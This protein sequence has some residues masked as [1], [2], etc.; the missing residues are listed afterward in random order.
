MKDSVTSHLIL[1]NN[2]AAHTDQTQFLDLEF[3]RA[4]TLKNGEL[5]IQGTR[6][7]FGESK[8]FPTLPVVGAF[9]ISLAEQM[10]T[11]M[12]ETSPAEEFRAVLDHFRA[13]S[14]PPSS[15]DDQ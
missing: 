6:H 14:H 15:R 11:K 3:V 4:N 1:V 7:V 13:P 9:Q 2:D 5:L 8:H 12:V 10:G